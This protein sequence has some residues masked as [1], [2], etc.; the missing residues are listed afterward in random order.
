MKIS[1]NRLLFYQKNNIIVQSGNR[2]QRN[3]VENSESWTVTLLAS[4][5]ID[6]GGGEMV[7]AMVSLAIVS[8]VAIICMYKLCKKHLTQTKK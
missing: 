5:V 7:I 8:I 6:E 3:K 1:S 2:Y 4:Y